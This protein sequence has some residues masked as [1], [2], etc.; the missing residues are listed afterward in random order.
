MAQSLKQFKREQAR[1][2]EKRLQSGTYPKDITIVAEGD[3]WFDYPLKKDIL[4]YLSKMGYGIKKFAVQGDTLENMIYG[5]EYKVKG[6]KATN[7]GPQSFQEVLYAIKK[8]KPQ[9]FLFSGGGNDIVGQEIIGYL[10]HYRSKPA[11]LI[12]KKIF[13]ARLAEMKNAIEYMIT[14]VHKTHKG[15]HILMDGYDFAKVNGKGY[16]FIIK[17]IRGPWILPSMGAKNI[18]KKKDQE[19]IITYLVNEFNKMLKSLDKKYPFF[20]HIDLRHQFPND[21]E[22]DNEI[23]LKNNGFKKVAQIYHNKISSIL[24]YDPLVTHKGKVIV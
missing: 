8:L 17:N 18:L 3:S 11:S 20:H 22:W 21:N 24:T 23:H 2:S 14:W 19:A 16:T 15:C 1:L 12:N 10:N 9:F 13:Q 5:T 7:P 6:D 4:N